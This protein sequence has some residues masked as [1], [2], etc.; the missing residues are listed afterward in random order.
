[1]SVDSREPWAKTPVWTVPCRLGGGAAWAAQLGGLSPPAQSA[2]L[3]L[4]P[5]AQCSVRLLSPPARTAATTVCSC[6]QAV[7]AH[8][9]GSL[10][11]AE[12][13]HLQ[14]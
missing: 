14:G 8:S 9:H 4:S 11:M 7:P 13:G 5:P 2:G 10:K 6:W 12:D 1:M 3:V